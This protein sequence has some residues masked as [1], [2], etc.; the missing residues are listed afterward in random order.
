LH[1]LKLLKNVQ[2]EPKLNSSLVLIFIYL[3]LSSSHKEGTSPKG[4]TEGSKKANV[5]INK[6]VFYLLIKSA[7]FIISTFI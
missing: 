4:G 2:S 3:Y 1:V 5:N 7:I 6:N